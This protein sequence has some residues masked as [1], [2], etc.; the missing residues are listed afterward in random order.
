MC[1]R[2]QRRE[3]GPQ[4]SSTGS[5]S[6]L[7]R[8]EVSQWPGTSHRKPSREWTDAEYWLRKSRTSV[9]GQWSERQGSTNC[10]SGGTGR[11][12][13]TTQT[14]NWLGTGWA[15]PREKIAHLLHK[16]HK[17]VSD[18]LIVGQL[19]SHVHQP[20]GQILWG[21]DLG[22][23]VFCSRGWRLST[24][25]EGGPGLFPNLSTSLNQISPFC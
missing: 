3:V 24:E 9:S 8:K 10:R 2:S 1:P 7:E 20:P 23:S 19:C 15:G 17:Q 16:V 22:S 13:K 21:R 6:L 5:L 25:A 18:I 4:S 11:I 12:T 14:Q